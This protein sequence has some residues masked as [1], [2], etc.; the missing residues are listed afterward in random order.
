MKMDSKI[1][2]AEWEIQLK[3]RQIIPANRMLSDDLSKGFVTL[4][5]L[6]TIAKYWGISQAKAEARILSETIPDDLLGK[7]IKVN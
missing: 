5:Q 4:A 6:R 2:D 3:K 1:S 7:L